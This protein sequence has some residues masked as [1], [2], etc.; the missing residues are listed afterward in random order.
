MQLSTIINICGK[1]SIVDV[2]NQI[3]KLRKNKLLETYLSTPI[4][5]LNKLIN[6]DKN[7][8]IFTKKYIKVLTLYTIFY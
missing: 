7:L 5:K 6:I 4:F 8:S 2:D 3:L 1:I